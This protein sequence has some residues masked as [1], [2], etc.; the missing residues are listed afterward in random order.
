MGSAAPEMRE[1]GEMTQEPLWTD[2]RIEDEMT[3]HMGDPHYIDDAMIVAKAIRDTY[4][5]AR[6]QK[7]AQR[8]DGWERGGD[9]CLSESSVSAPKDGA[10]PKT[11]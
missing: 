11:P 4:E 5:A 3:R 1:R 9:R 6:A 7:P 10:N 8:R 2:E